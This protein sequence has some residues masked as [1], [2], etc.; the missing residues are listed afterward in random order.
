M[1]K[2][3]KVPEVA[4]NVTEGKVVSILVD[5]GDEIEADQS[6]LELETEKA[7]VAIPAPF[8]GVV[9][10][11]KVGEGDTVAVGDVIVMLETDAKAPRAEAAEPP[12]KAEGPESQADREGRAEV[13]EEEE[14]AEGEPEEE[15]EGPEEPKQPEKEPEKRPEPTAAPRAR[16]TEPEEVAPASP[17]VRRLARKLGADIHAIAGTGPTGR[18]TAQDVRDH[19]KRIV[20][21]AERGAAPAWSGGA[22]L[23]D[24]SRWGP[25]RTEP[26]SRVREITAEV[27]TR[28]WTTIPQVTQR[29]R[30]DIT[31]LEEFRLSYNHRLPEE[32]VRLSLT[33]VL[34]KVCATALR[35]FPRFNTSLDV[36]H[37][38]L[39]YKLYV[40]IGVAVDTDRGLLV[41]VVRGVDAKGIAELSAEL[42]ELAAA[43]RNKAIQPGQMEGGNFSISNLGGIGG[44]G[45][46]PIVYPP[47]VAILGVSRA[48][49]EPVH[50]E[51]RFESRLLLPL[52]LSYDHRVIDGADGARFLRWICEALEQPWLL[53]T[54]G[55]A[56]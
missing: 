52:A 10:E 29:D 5:V 18:I 43:A 14:A 31:D 3:V 49:T 8:A 1:L 35:T 23:P 56:S 4:E 41:P 15:P 16:E 25:T 9:R 21:S 53:V 42:A 2:E 17:S 6:L 26:L 46:D 44:T 37:R 24:F 11:I 7:V 27:M 30:A 28:A 54:K 13:E 22:E 47:Q 51:G 55:P 40:D 39:V 33:A 20:Q 38:S 45:F 19:V 34:L 50:R 48:S 32:G 12:E 36:R